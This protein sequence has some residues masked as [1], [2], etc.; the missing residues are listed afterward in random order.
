MQQNTEQRRKLITWTLLLSTVAT[1]A[2]DSINPIAIS[3]KFVLQGMVKKAK[4]I[5]YFIISIAITN[6]VG[7][8]LAYFGL[9]APIGNF[10]GWII[11]KYG[12]AIFSL[13]LIVGIGFLIAIGYSLQNRKTAGLEKQLSSLQLDENSLKDDESKVK[14]GIKSVTPLSLA[15]LGIVATITE[16]T[17]ALPYFVFLGIL[18]QYKLTLP[19]VIGILVL[20]NII[21]SLPLII[22]YFINVKALDKFDRFYAFLKHQME[23]W[24]A[25]LMPVVLGAVGLLLM[26]HSSSYLLK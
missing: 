4:H 3:Q 21:Y 26:F 12:Q 25:A 18:F 15:L 22:L 2:A 17:S 23:R 16:L 7:G 5:W 19:A 9:V 1:S 14:A 6:F 20:Y 13:E 8:F 10:M 24:A 11:G